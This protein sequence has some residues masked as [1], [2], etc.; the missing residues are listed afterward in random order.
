[1]VQPVRSTIYRNKTIGDAAILYL[2]SVGV[3][4]KTRE[5]ADALESGGAH[6]SDMYRAVYNALDGGD[7][8]HQVDGKRWALQ[9]WDGN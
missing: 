8:A 7:L 1:V 3:P 6:S 5:I 4:Q 2:K 9:E